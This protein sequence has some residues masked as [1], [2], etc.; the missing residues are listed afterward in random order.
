MDPL[1]SVFS[2]YLLMLEGY[3]FQAFQ[4]QTF[5]FK[6]QHNACAATRDMRNA[7]QVPSATILGMCGLGCTSEGV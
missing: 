4:L 1:D 2:H 7:E 6:C 3:V 5:G